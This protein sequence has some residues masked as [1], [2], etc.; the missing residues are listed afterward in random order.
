MGE[1]NQQGQSNRLPPELCGKDYKGWHHLTTGV[2]NLWEYTEDNTVHFPKLY[3]WFKGGLENLFCIRIE[4]EPEDQ[5]V[6]AASARGLQHPTFIRISF[7]ASPSF[8]EMFVSPKPI[9]SHVI[10]MRQTSNQRD[11]L[12]QAKRDLVVRFMEQLVNSTIPDVEKVC[13]LKK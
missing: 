13:T 7:M 6:K 10:L 11:V 9:E 8:G 2:N 1:T 4:N 5:I 3:D 12:V